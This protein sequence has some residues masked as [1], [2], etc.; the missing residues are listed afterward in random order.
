MASHTPFSRR[1]LLR[2]VAA[3]TSL[4]ATQS[5][6]PG[7]ARAA[8]NR[9]GGLHHPAPGPVAMDLTISQP[10]L[11]IAGRTTRRGMAINGTIP[12]PLIQLHE[13]HEAVL[14][15][16]NRLDADSSIHWHGILLPY[17]MD[18]VPGVTYPG[19]APGATFEARFP[20]KQAGTYWYHSHSDLQEQSG[21]YGPLIIHP[22]QPEAYAYDRDYVVL[23]SDWTF[24]DPHA[25]L[26]RLKKLSH[27]YAPPQTVADL[28]NAAKSEGFGPAFR[29]WAA[30][31]AMRMSPTD[32][33][34]V[35]ARTYHYLLNGQSAA[36]NWTALFA[37]GERI[38]LRFINASAMTY[39]NVRI[40][41]LP[42]TVVQSDGQDVQPVETDEFQ[43][44][45]AETLDVIVRP[46]AERAYTLFAESMDRSGFVRG[47]LAP[48]PGM[49]A[50]VPALRDP[51]RRT[52]RDMGMDH[53]NHEGSSQAMARGAD[54]ND[55]AGA[56]HADHSAHAAHAHSG[57]AGHDGMQS[58]PHAARHGPDTHGAGNI[59]VAQVQ[60]RRLS[61]PGTG[62]ADAGHRVLTYADLQRFSHDFDR[63]PPDRELELHLTGNMERY[64]WSFDGVKYQ[65][66]AA[67]I[68]FHLGERLRLVL[69]NDTMMEHP[70][71]LHGL[72]MEL[73]NGH[74]HR[75]P[76][77]HT[78]SV[79]PAERLSVLINADAPGRW[80]F[81]CHLLYHMKMGMMQVVEVA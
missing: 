10:E 41:G 20:V 79:K 9:T 56:S 24:E 17:E 66:V 68:R 33:A 74:G 53:G 61:E 7:W 80:A 1:D 63:R 71:H 46:A 4:I 42:M 2:G 73:E 55:Q 8:A 48:R 16:T 78:V 15:V 37:P 69:V 36:E 47:T 29:E 72:W 62:L 64:M 59:G 21:V 38:R 50:A 23:L 40:P 54:A 28:F 3:T 5:L 25:V 31:E 81:H 52:M 43:L 26:G 11:T 65:H 12:G 76:R 18:G 60:Y 13:G 14:R 6:L 77:Q 51:P 22:T 44:A 39:F 27:Y 75:I 34:D 19:I 45:V 70:I 35:S 49:A 32:I 57:H 58:A 67:P 30:W